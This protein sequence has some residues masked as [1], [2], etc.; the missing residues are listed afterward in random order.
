[1]NR[2]LGVIAVILLPLQLTLFTGCGGNGN[3][4]SDAILAYQDPGDDIFPVDECFSLDY[5]LD[6]VDD[7]QYLLSDVSDIILTDDYA[8]ILDQRNAV[9]KVDLKS[10]KVVNQLFQLGRG[11]EDYLKPIKLTAG[12][13]RLYLLDFVSKKVHVYD[14]DFN[15]LDRL[16]VEYITTPSSFLK[17]K[18]G[19]LFLNCDRDA[20]IGTFVVTDDN[21]VMRTS[22]LEQTEDP[23]LSAVDSEGNVIDL[24]MIFT[25][26]YFFAQPNGDVLC[27]DP[28]ADDVYL[29]DGKTFK[30]Q[31]SIKPDNSLEGTRGVNLA[32][33][34]CLDGN[35]LVGYRYNFKPSFAWYDKECNLIAKGCAQIVNQRFQIYQSANRIVITSVEQDSQSDDKPVQ[36]QISVYKP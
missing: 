36:G 19:F 3:V 29:Y 30:K 20:G 17:L 23:S 11:P 35:T 33:I 15:H 14:F 4:T 34:L 27:H 18:D 2:I 9:S 32:K 8:F 24:R 28:N 22:F 10:G 5:K 12:N 7:G 1:M 25:G 26:D 21:G 16:D 13:D 6:I 31:F